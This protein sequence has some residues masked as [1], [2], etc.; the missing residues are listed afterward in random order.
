MLDS[1]E[2]MIEKDKQL[3][4]EL[5][6]LNK[7]IRGFPKNGI[8]PAEFELLKEQAGYMAS[9]GYTLKTRISRAVHK[10]EAA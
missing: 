7:V 8:H 4:K 10:T 6:E 2:V 1:L 9:Y 3:F 5:Q